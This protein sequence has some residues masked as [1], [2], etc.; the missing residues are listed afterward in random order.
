MRG[1]MCS[2]LNPMLAASYSMTALHHLDNLQPL[3]G[4]LF[5]KWADKASSP[6]RFDSDSLAPPRCRTNLCRSWSIHGKPTLNCLELNCHLAASSPS[7]P[8]SPSASCA[9]P[10]AQF[11]WLPLLHPPP[12]YCAA[13]SATLAAALSLTS[14]AQPGARLSKPCAPDL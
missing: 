10:A 6:S 12:I 4:Q 7:D 3:P 5:D 2:I 1:K 13:L 11:R 8:N 14:N 9:G